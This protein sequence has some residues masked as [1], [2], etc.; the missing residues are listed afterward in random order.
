MQTNGDRSGTSPTS[1][2][3][4]GGITVQE[5][6]HLLGTSVDGVRSRIK[7]GTLDSMKVGGQVFVLLGPDQS[8]PSPDQ[9]GLGETSPRPDPPSH[10]GE[11]LLAAK[12]ET[13]HHLRRELDARNEELRRKD[14]I[15]MALTQRIPELEASQDVQEDAQEPRHGTGGVEDGE[16]PEG[17]SWW[18]RVFGG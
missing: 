11:A 17:R 16:E 2:R 6:A 1:P 18:R 10:E 7:R 13:I 15:I 3:P 14:H 5:A 4:G 9:P 8:P 12:D